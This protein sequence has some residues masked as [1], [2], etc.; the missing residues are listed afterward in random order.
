MMPGERADRD[1]R[2]GRPVGRGADLRDGAAGQLGQDREAG[3][4]RDL[5]LVGRHAERGVA[6]EVL[7][8]A[9]A[10]ALGERDVV[11]GHVVLEIDEGLAALAFDVPER[12]DGDRLVVGA[13]AARAG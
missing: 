1:R 2:V 13:S 12:R 10:L 5:A 9:E 4:V 8:R 3:D 6:L 11:G 7:D